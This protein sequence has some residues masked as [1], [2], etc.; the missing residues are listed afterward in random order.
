[1][2]KFF[3]FIIILLVIQVGLSVLA[4]RE[5]TLTHISDSLDTLYKRI[6]SDALYKDGK[7]DTSLYNAD[8]DT[9]HPHGSSGFTNP[10]YIITVDGFIIE[11][12]QP[13]EGFL[14]T[15]DFEHLQAFNQP[16]TVAIVTNDQW[17]ILSKPIINK[18]GETIGTVAVSLHNPETSLS[19]DIDKKL[20]KNSNMIISNIKINTNN[21]INTSSVDIRQVDYN[22]AF[23]IVDKFNKVLLNT[24]RMPIFIDPSY[25]TRETK[26]IGTTRVVYDAKTN[27]PFFIKSYGIRDKNNELK[28]LVVAGNSLTFLEILYTKF[29]IF[30]LS[31]N[32]AV[33]ALCMFFFNK[34]KSWIQ[35]EGINTLPKSLSFNSRENILFVDDKEFSIPY[36]TN[37]YY[38]CK[39]IFSA[40]QKKWEIDELLR[41]F[42]ELEENPNWRKVYDAVL[43]LNKKVNFKLIDYKDKLIR[44]NPELIDKVK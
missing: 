9:P 39:A 6:Q 7:W 8:P 36:A 44:L 16:Q 27:V 28:G 18:R 37:Q 22:V 31:I 19:A 29:S 25:V 12:T 34:F 5:I 23:T 10:L 17:R 2:K 32:I 33:F 43:A 41:R 20:D 15:A 26:Q 35:I 40:P 38:I 1:M 24:G 14:D 3:A 42:G 21:S 13:I 30:L 4:I 11:R